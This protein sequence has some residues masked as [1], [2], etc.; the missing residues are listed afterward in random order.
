MHWLDIVLIIPILIGAWLG[1]RN[2]FI[3]TITTLIAFALAIYAGLWFS[4]TVSGWIL[5]LMSRPNEYVPLI[6]FSICFLAVCALVFFIGKWLHRLARIVLLGSL[7]KI[8]GGL[9]GLVQ[10]TLIVSV[11]MVI[12]DAYAAKKNSGAPAWRE[13]SLLYHPLSGMVHSL[14]PGLEEQLQIV[15]TVEE[16]HETIESSNSKKQ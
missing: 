15:F 4:D 11:L 7:D 3:L 2:G 13:E 8:I 14:I 1:F 9:F 6:S 10:F 16:I 5:S 12:V